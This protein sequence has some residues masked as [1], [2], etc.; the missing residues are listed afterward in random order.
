MKSAVPV[1]LFGEIHARFDPPS[2]PLFIEVRKHLKSFHFTVLSGKFLKRVF[3]AMKPVQ[4]KIRFFISDTSYIIDIPVG[5]ST[6][7]C[8]V[9]A[10]FFNEWHCRNFVNILMSTKE[11]NCNYL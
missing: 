4:K 2:H 7:T 3:L 6:D 5:L 9:Q 10:I 1:I 11:H 8:T